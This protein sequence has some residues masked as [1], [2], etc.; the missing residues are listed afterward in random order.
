MFHTAHDPSGK[1]IICGKAFDCMRSGNY[2]LSIGD[3]AYANKTFVEQ[4]GSGIHCDNN[5]EAIFEAL[6]TIYTKWKE[7]TL[8]GGSRGIEQ[9]S[10]DYQNTQFLKMIR[11][12]T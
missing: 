9:Y 11:D 6:E 7:G 1:Y 8:T 10:R 12:L 4:T 2:L 5:R 3:V